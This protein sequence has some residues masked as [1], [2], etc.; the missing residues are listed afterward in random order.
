VAVP[1][2]YEPFEKD[3][4]IFSDALSAHGVRDVFRNLRYGSKN[5]LFWHMNRDGRRD[6]TLFVK[7]HQSKSGLIRVVSDFALF[8]LGIDNP[9]CD[10]SLELGLFDV[11]DD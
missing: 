9:E 10:R 2:L 11:T 8:L 7:G 6:N 5:V 3:G 4:H 1:W